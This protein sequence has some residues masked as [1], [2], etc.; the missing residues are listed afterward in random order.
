MDYFSGTLS[1]EPLPQ[2]EMQIQSKCVASRFSAV[3]QARQCCRPLLRTCA[4]ARS[5]MCYR[6][7]LSS[8]SSPS[9]IALRIFIGALHYPHWPDGEA[10]ARSISTET[11][12]PGRYVRDAPSVRRAQR[13]RNPPERQTRVP[14]VLLE[15]SPIT[16]A[17]LR[18]PPR[19]R[20]HAR[21]P[22][23]GA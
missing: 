9:S 20:A 11:V 7:L 14:R 17:P 21:L 22:A 23:L 18:Y 3:L 19:E 8:S 5:D 12:P 6:S 2:R 10:A 4:Q 13:L 16:D 1:S 15:I